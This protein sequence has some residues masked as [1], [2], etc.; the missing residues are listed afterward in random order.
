MKEADSD[1]LSPALVE[2]TN[3]DKLT[4]AILEMGDEIIVSNIDSRQAK[5]RSKDK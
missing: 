1:L 4:L 2:S 5:D 3:D